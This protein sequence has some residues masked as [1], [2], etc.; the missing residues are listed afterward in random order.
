MKCC[1]A[2]T[3]S[4]LENY[5]LAVLRTGI[6]HQAPC[7]SLQHSCSRSSSPLWPAMGGSPPGSLP[8]GPSA[9]GPGAAAPRPVGSRR[10]HRRSG[11]PGH[12]APGCTGDKWQGRG[13]RR[14]LVCQGVTSGWTLAGVGIVPGGRMKP[15]DGYG[16]IKAH[17]LQASSHPGCW[18]GSGHTRLSRSTSPRSRGY[19]LVQ[20]FTRNVYGK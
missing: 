19:F 8:A 14:H 5:L 20:I 3:L 11:Q 12:R 6:G 4:S 1:F 9:A 16:S 7:P 18:H 13:A 15:G 2:L 17:L 10:G